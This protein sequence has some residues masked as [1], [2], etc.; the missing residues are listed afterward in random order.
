M[1][2]PDQPD[3]PPEAPDPESN[4]PATP[5]K[6]IGPYEILGEIGRGGMGI[7]YK[8]YHPALKRTV[9][10]K[11][12][13]A[14]E[15]ASE[16]AI[17]RF[18]GEAEAVAKLGHHPNIV[19]VHDIGV[20]GNRH[21]FAMHFVEGK[22]LEKMIDE[23]EMQP[24]LAASITKKLAEALAHA[25]S[26]GILHRDIKPANVLMAFPRL[27]GEPPGGPKGEIPNPKSQI[28][29]KSQI[30][31]LNDTGSGPSGRAEGESGSEPLLTDF[32]LA[33]DV[34]SET[35]LTRTG[36]TLGTPA[37][38]SPEQASGRISE[39]DERSDVYSLGATFY[40]MLA[41]HP[42]FDG[43]AIIEILQKVVLKDPVPLRKGNPTLHRDLET[44]CLKCLEKA[45]AK[46]Y[47]SAQALAEDLGRYLKDTAILA[48][49]TPGWEKWLR[50]ARRNRAVSVAALIILLLLLAGVL[51]TTGFWERLT[52]ERSGKEEAERK[53]Q[54]AKAG[55]KEAL[56]LLTKGRQAT[57]VLL[58]AATRF[59]RILVDLKRSYYDARKTVEK[60]QE[61]FGKNRKEIEDF[62][63]SLARDSASQAT[64]LAVKGWLLYLGAFEKEALSH[65]KESQT[66]DP[67]VP[68]GFFFEAMVWLEKYL[69]AQNL[70]LAIS[71]DRALKYHEYVAETPAVRKARE[72][73]LSL[74]S[75]ETP[76]GDWL[77]FI[78][79]DVR[80]ALK[81]FRGFQEG[82]LENAEAGLTRA[83]SLPEFSWIRSE[84]LLLRAKVRYQRKDFTGGLEDVKSVLTEQPD[85]AKAHFYKG[86]I[87]KGVGLTQKMKKTDARKAF[88]EAI[89]AFGICLQ[90]DPGNGAAFINRSN[91]YS[92]LAQEEALRGGGD[93]EAGHRQA[94]EDATRAVEVEPFPALAYLCLGNG[95]FG[96]GQ[97]RAA[98]GENPREEYRKAIAEYA[99]A[100]ENDPKLAI[101]LRNRGG[102]RATL[103]EVLR[104]AGEDSRTLFREA[105]QD[106]TQ[107]YTMDPAPGV[108]SERA[109]AYSKLGN[110]LYAIDRDPF[111]AYRQA[112]ADCTEALRLNPQDAEV[113][114]LRG[115]VYLDMGTAEEAR[116]KEPWESLQ[117]S[118]RD[119]VAALR[120]D[121]HSALTHNNLGHTHAVLG[122]ALFDRGKDSRDAYGKAV[123]S[124]SRALEEDPD[125]HFPWNNRANAYRILGEEAVAR[126]GDP[127]T[128]FEKAIADGREA[129]LRKPNSIQ[130][131]NNLGAAFLAL[132][133]FQASKGE[134]PREVFGLSLEPFEKGLALAP[135]NLTLLFNR[136]R[137]FICLGDAEA[138]RG[139]KAE[140]FFEKAVEAYAEVIRRD[141]AHWR[142]WGNQ[143]EGLER[144]GRFAEA[145]KA[146]ET[147]LERGGN[148]FP[149]LRE[150]LARARKKAED[151]KDGGK[152]R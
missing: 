50:K 75:E 106:F 8:A 84:T 147:A 104:K 42:P 65:L 54:T 28:P 21:Y 33:K 136:A 94:I 118:V 40:E 102:A 144:L 142:A 108:L 135:G 39:I 127:K 52:R 69:S 100:L 37:Y 129:L 74:L 56:R 4:V 97:I 109:L 143:G 55:E 41:L 133:E 6:R 111:P 76:S 78:S 17:T 5:E 70:P 79:E 57:R 34:A 53:E 68:W 10:L 23:G 32:G 116:G 86:G 122:R 2:S 30:P 19:P 38:M 125:L 91:A 47:A 12:L 117:H 115:V 45:P 107:S 26:H 140:P 15:D 51:T 7:V 121:P 87:W 24:K 139:G 130:T 44:I 61:T 77:R 149:P 46:R 3:R 73:F 35:G 90:L 82:N 148:V 80:E 71:E 113:Y 145:V 36:M 83:L 132:G 120:I 126:G 110:A 123:Q 14:G 131:L 89:Q 66:L 1:G 99:K 96:L 25:H 124:F 119:F 85:N 151:E 60:K 103:G 9:A 27:E 16:D 48:H 72:R 29:T 152:K 114:D 49:P 31:N 105:I 81:N 63:R 13:I 128:L 95:L 141:P 138:V 112:V 43:N 11:V 98:R 22:S 101:A 137:V 146:Y 92:C 67:E 58:G 93:P 20:E 150:W 64:W 62:G 18:H 59:A 88:R 134:D